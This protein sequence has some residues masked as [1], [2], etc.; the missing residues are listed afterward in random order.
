MNNDAVE[1]TLKVIAVLE[2]YNIP[3]VLVGSLA[4]AAHGVSRSTLD[5][6][7]LAAIHPAHIDMLVETL[8]TE[9]YISAPAIEEAI[10]HHSSFNLIHLSA[11]FKVD[12]FIAKPRPFDQA[13]LRRG[14]P[15]VV[16]HDPERVAL[17][18]SPED[19]IL[20]KLEWFRSDGKV[21]EN[22]RQDVLAII[23]VQG[24]RL[25]LAYLRRTAVELQIEDLLE[26]IL[27]SKP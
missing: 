27:S 22:Q 24:D 20:A 16:A 11:F 9:F 7:L 4:G 5:G 18:A 13:E 1:V 15:L 12:I 26:K 23:Q 8:E 25:D 19:T 6:D 21:S 17:V 2:R 3:Y 14:Q 10:R